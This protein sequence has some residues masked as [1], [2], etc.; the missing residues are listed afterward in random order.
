MYR[1]GGNGGPGGDGEHGKAGSNGG[2]SGN[3]GTVDVWVKQ[4]D[5]ALLDTISL[6]D[7]SAGIPGKAGKHG[8][9]GCGGRGGRGGSSYSW[10]EPYTVEHTELTQWIELNIG[11]IMKGTVIAM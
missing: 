5:L 1:P 7:V 3:G 9:G 10:S 11:Q 8:T 2:N 6:I 4:E